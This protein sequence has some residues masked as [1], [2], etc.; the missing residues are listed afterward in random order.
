LETTIGVAAAL[1]LLL[2][3]QRSLVLLIAG[4]AI[5]LDV[6]ASV[7]LRWRRRRRLRTLRGFLSLSPAGFEVAVAAL[8]RRI[9]YR[10]VLV[11]GGAGD[12]AAD[13]VCRGPA[14][15]R[16]VVHC[17]RYAP[18]H[19][20]GSPQLQ[21]FVGMAFVHHRAARAVFVTTSSFTPPARHLARTHPIELIDGPR[22]VELAQRHPRPRRSAGRTPRGKEVPVP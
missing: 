14:D 16:V 21:A 22:L 2:G 15:E 12:L 4:G 17:K 3:V 19:P 20:V 18:G 13:I 8:L 1:A 6:A 7:V 10:R 11:V 9:G 5:A